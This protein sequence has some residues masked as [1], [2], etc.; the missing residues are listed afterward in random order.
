MTRSS[1][2]NPCEPKRSKNA[3]WGLMTAT[4]SLTASSDREARRTRDLRPCRCRPQPSMSARLGSMPT[5]SGPRSRT[6]SWSRTPKLS[7]MGHSNQI[8]TRATS[9]RRIQ[10]SSPEGPA[11]ARAGPRRSLFPPRARSPRPSA[12]PRRP[13]PKRRRPL[14]RSASSRTPRDTRRPRASATGRIPVRSRHRHRCRATPRDVEVDTQ[15]EHGVHQ[16]QARRT[17]VEGGA[18]DLDEVGVFGTQLDP[19]GQIRLRVMPRPPPPSPTPSARTSSNDSR[20][21]DN[22]RSPRAPRCPLPSSH[23]PPRRTQRRCAPRWNPPRARR[24]AS[25][26]GR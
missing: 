10:R 17:R 26:A 12:S 18:G 6:R 24:A 22:S 9:C 21:S 5:H 13:R 11:T 23:V 19:Q 14:P 3:T 8:R 16:H 7:T 20:G 15:P 4:V 2:R 1:T 25:S